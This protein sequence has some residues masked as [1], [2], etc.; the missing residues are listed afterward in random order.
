MSSMPKPNFLVSAIQL[1]LLFLM[2]Y[3]CF[4]IVKPFTIPVIWG[5]ILAISLYPL[6]LKIARS[7]GGRLKLSATLISLVGISLIILPLALF[8]TASWEHGSHF[9]ELATSGELKVPPPSMSVKEWPVFGPDLYNFWLAASR[10]LETTLITHA[11]A[12]KD[13]FGTMVGTV[14]GIVGSAFAFVFSLI[15]AGIFLTKAEESSKFASIVASGLAGAHGPNLVTLVSQTI[16][17]V[18]TGVIGVAAIQAVA[19]TIGMA[20]VGIPGSAIFGLII[21]ILA[22]SQLP[23]III[24]G[25]MAAYVFS[26]SPGTPAVLFLIWSLVVSASDGFLK[27][28]FLG[29]GM[30]IPM[31]V[32]LLGAIGGML[33]AGILGLFVGAVFLALGYTIFMAWLEGEHPQTS[34]EV[35]REHS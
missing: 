27:P 9:F 25:P 35:E 15:I 10:N 26:V 5:M 24:L 33:L 21:M 20:L 18:A 17:S 14:G 30:E 6:H 34:E 13:I 29:R 8:G 7:L 23:P 19:A 2:L 22:I 28:M 1:A 4:L 31:L 32:I 12:I 16:K 3:V 11:A